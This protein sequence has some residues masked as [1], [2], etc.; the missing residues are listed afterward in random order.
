MTPAEQVRA[1]FASLPPAARRC[2]RK[3]RETI[4]AAAPGA[5]EAF[6]YGIPAFKLDGRMLVWYAAFKHH[7]SL[8]P[9]RRTSRD[10]RR[11]RA[12]SDFHSRSC[13]QRDW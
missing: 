6:S 11:R 1:Y 4:R 7:C 10:T 3:L 5:V 8:Y 2:L 12:R 13:R 9:T